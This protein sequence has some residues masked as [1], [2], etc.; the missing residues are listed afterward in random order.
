MGTGLLALGTIYIFGVLLTVYSRLETHIHR[1][2]CCR[3]AYHRWPSGWERRHNLTHKDIAGMTADTRQL[4]DG[5]LVNSL[6][7]ARYSVHN[8]LN[9][10]FLKAS[11]TGDIG[12]IH[13]L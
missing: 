12:Y 2:H 5:T 4:D 10:C 13:L 9:L 8:D 1:L 3:C 7:S 11:L 6:Y